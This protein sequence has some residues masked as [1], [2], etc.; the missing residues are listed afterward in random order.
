MSEED[1]PPSDQELSAGKEG[2][3]HVET[4]TG[5]SERKVL[6]ACA[7]CGT[8]QDFPVC[9]ECG[10][11]MHYEETKFTCHGEKPIPEHCGETMVPKIV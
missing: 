6:L 5:I 8:T 3:A 10:E 11:A 7:K 4:K 9:D 1:K 2:L